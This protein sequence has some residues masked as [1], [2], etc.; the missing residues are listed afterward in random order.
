VSTSAP[1]TEIEQAPATTGQA[2][3]TITE[4]SPIASG[5][6]TLRDKY[7][8]RVWDL[9]TTAG[10]KEARQAR[11]TLV[12][13][14]GQVES[15]RKTLK[16]E[17]LERGR[18]IDTVAKSITS[19]I[20]KIEEPIGAAIQASERKK[21]EERKARMEAEATRIKA[22]KDLIGSM[23][24]GVTKAIREGQSSVTATILE[25]MTNRVIEEARY[26]EFTEEATA[27]RDGCI[28]QLT[29]ILADQQNTENER[30]EL[31][32]LRKESEARKAADAKRVKEE[33][34]AKEIEAKRV[35]GIKKQLAN[36]ASIVR[37]GT[38]AETIAEAMGHRYELAK[39]VIDESFAEFQDE[40][41]VSKHAGLDSIKDRIDALNEAIKLADDRAKLKKEQEETE[42]KQRER[43]REIDE[44]EARFKAEREKA[45]HEQA[46]L[47]AKLAMQEKA[48]AEAILADSATQPESIPFD[49]P[50]DADDQIEPEGDSSHI[51]HGLQ[52]INTS[53]PTGTSI[54]HLMRAFNA[55]VDHCEIHLPKDMESAVVLSEAREA[56]AGFTY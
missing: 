46:E 24:S 40:A 19:E 45:E 39:L 8:G 12:K 16:A 7:A 14:R 41:M 53:K 5:I 31:E 17:V 38:R 32:R 55:L 27:V 35:N 9:A 30:A 54:Y 13:L 42:A 3:T 49:A 56:I 33:A 10:D 50:I 20:E 44:Q 1:V 21:E 18:Q 2:T 37:C 23:P 25:K 47:Q 15:T 29:G 11:Q 34:E 4:F 43:Q 52:A 28:I 48:S 6:A 51:P 26:E 36:I 22:I